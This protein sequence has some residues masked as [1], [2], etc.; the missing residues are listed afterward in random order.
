MTT[1]WSDSDW[2]R[3]CYIES[4]LKNEFYPKYNRPRT[5]NPF[6][7]SYKAYMGHKIKTL[8]K[9]FYP[10]FQH[11][12]VKGLDNQLKQAKIFDMFC[13]KENI[14][15]NDYTAF[16]NS[17]TEAIMYAC[18]LPFLDYL[19]PLM[20]EHEFLRFKTIHA[21]TNILKTRFKCKFTVPATRQSGTHATAFSNLF[22][23]ILVTLFSLYKSSGL[24]MVDFIHDYESYITLVAEGDD[25]LF[26]TKQF[27][28]DMNTIEQLGFR[29]KPEYA[30]TIDDTSFCNYRFNSET[31]TCYLDPL[32]T[33]LRFGWSDVK[34]WHSKSKHALALA[35]ALSIAFSC[36]NC[37]IIYPFCYFIIRTYSRVQINARDLIKANPQLANDDTSVEKILSY[38]FPEPDVKTADRIRYEELFSITVCDQILIEAELIQTQP[39]HSPTLDNY[40]PLEYF[41]AWNHCVKNRVEPESFVDCESLIMDITKL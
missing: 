18:E 10:I 27:S 22:T 12:H 24:A 41:E 36:V 20:E 14:Q 28:I 16:E 11:M 6:H 37:P 7:D 17:L 30:N 34:Y 4:F 32:R 2:V 15:L 38:D 26:S 1:T 39:P 3:M 33:I 21:G 29:A 23:N 35:K 13:D 31:G 9:H 19:K 5:I 8:E 40:I 25:M